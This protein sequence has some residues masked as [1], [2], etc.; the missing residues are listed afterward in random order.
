MSIRFSPIGLWLIGTLISTC[1]AADEG[2]RADDHAPIGVMADHYHGVGE[3]MFSYRYMSMSM[4]GN[5]AGDDSI[6]PSTI[7][8]SVPNRF[9]GRPMQPPTL[10]VVPTEM[11]MEMH[12]LGLMYAPTAHLTLMAMVNQ[13]SKD[14]D[15]ITFQG[16]AGTQQLGTFTTSTSGLGDTSLAALVRMTETEDSRLHA[17]VGLS[18]PTGDID[19]TGTILAP[20]GMRPTPR[21]PYPMQLG[22]GTYDLIGGLTF[23]RFHERW[24]WGSQWRSVIRTGDNDEGYAFGDEHRLTAWYSRLLTPGIS[25]SARLEYFDR[26]NIDGIDPLIVAP[27]QTADPSRQGGSRLDAAVGLNFANEGGHRLALEVLVPLEQDLDG[28]Q[29]ETDTQLM[30]GYQFSF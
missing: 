14:M 20:T 27:V 13:V 3:F 19:A 29:L 24:S 7:A 28:P 21:L 5:L 12:M 22:S 4:K 8:T 2:L 11:T 15:H 25:W 17:T 1:V 16:P 10:R 6:S 26:G 23:S 9:F 30:L 18:L